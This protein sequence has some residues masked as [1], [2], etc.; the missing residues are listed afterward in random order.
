M[1]LLS[2]AVLA[3]GLLTVAALGLLLWP[4]GDEA[5]EGREGA[6]EAAL[7]DESEVAGEEARPPQPPNPGGSRA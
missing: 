6:H 7:V 3:V 5:A 4:A 1:S 2:L